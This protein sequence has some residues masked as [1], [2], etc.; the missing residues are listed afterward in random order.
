[1][2]TRKA[3]KWLWMNRENMWLEWVLATPAEGG[4]AQ[5]AAMHADLT[6]AVRPTDLAACSSCGKDRGPGSGGWEEI[7]LCG[8]CHKEAPGLR[9]VMQLKCVIVLAEIARQ[10]WGSKG[11]KVARSLAT[12]KRVGEVL[13]GG[14]QQL[15]WK[16]VDVVRQAGGFRS[17]ALLPTEWSTSYHVGYGC[18]QIK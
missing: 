15:W 10:L 12:W 3:Q 16:V 4:M 9:E 1:M 8:K 11:H 18:M 13:Q 7:Q 17:H 14:K 2:V 6:E 5:H